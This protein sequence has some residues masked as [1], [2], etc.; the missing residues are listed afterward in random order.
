M[1]G[2]DGKPRIEVTWEETLDHPISEA[3]AGRR[4]GFG[5]LLLEQLTPRAV[6][7]QASLVF[8]PQA[9]RW[10]VGFPA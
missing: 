10:Q 8:E 1:E 9:V 2:P 5:R 7:G 6:K 4:R 3:P